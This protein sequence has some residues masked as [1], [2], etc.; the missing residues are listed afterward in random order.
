MPIT[1]NNITNN[2]NNIVGTDGVVPVL[3][4][5]SRW[6]WWNITEIF[7]GGI[8]A[9]KYVPKVNDYVM[10]SDNYTVYIVTAVDPT[11]LLSTLLEIKPSITTNAFSNDDILFGVGPGTQSDTY[12]IYYDNSVL[13]H[14]LAVDA[15][16]KVGGSMCSY[17]KIF[18]GSDVSTTSG[19]VISRLYNQSGTLL[20]ENVPLEL[21]AVDSH[22]NHSIRTV[23]VCYTNEVLKDGEIVT[24]V[25]YSDQGNVV[26]KRQL[27]VEN[28]S[29]I[30]SL[31]ASRKYISSISLDS[32]FITPTVDGVINFPLN[33]PIN[34][35]NLMGVVHYSDGSTLRMPVDGTKFK[36]HGIDQ[37][38]STIVG[39]KIELVLSYSLSNDETVYGAV[40]SDGK[41]V[42]APYSIITTKTDG[43]YMVKLYGYPVWIDA[44]NGYRMQWFLY[45]LDR[46]MIYDA[47][48]YVSYSITRP[49]FDPTAYGVLQRLVVMVNLN[50]LS[51]AF[52]SFI[53]TQSVDVILKQP[54]DD[55][56]TN[57]V[58]GYESNTLQPLYGEG[59]KA[60]V[61]GSTINISSGII[62]Y[63]E[64]LERMYLQTYPIVDPS[65]EVN[66]PTPNYF[67]IVYDGN[68]FEFPIESWDNPLNVGVPPF[69]N[70]TIYVQFFKRTPNADIQLS[71]AGLSVK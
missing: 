39:Q 66:A 24:V 54:G 25:F 71:I 5:T 33:V 49:A 55:A 23:S 16:L 53:H 63:P 62:S 21:A 38:I 35:L 7:T 58:V 52:K 69:L 45:N 43:S 11:T 15:R 50:N 59:L 34:A 19:R 28:T 10:D 51:G 37:Y 13:P 56:R 12:R 9:T 42:T 6:C 60:T 4:P 30:R 67:A 22:T 3:D 14:I 17:A 40:T 41:Y 46:N 27:L 64:W 47:T 31:D 18:K 20:T 36:I 65:I 44:V 32:P 29:F 48:L 2:I 61:S 1:D 26:S 57:W 70:K 8:G 68:R